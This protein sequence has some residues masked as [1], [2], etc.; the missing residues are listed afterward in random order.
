MSAK[1]ATGAGHMPM[2]R[3]TLHIP[4]PADCGGLARNTVL[5]P[6]S[7]GQTSFTAITPAVLVM[8]RSWGARSGNTGGG[9]RRVERFQTEEGQLAVDPDEQVQP[10]QRTALALP[11]MRPERGG[12]RVP[13]LALRVGKVAK[14]PRLL[15]QMPADFRLAFG[16]RVSRNNAAAAYG[17]IAASKHDCRWIFLCKG[18][19]F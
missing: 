4:T 19:M 15:R 5:S 11:G 7:A 12:G 16:S 2:M 3:N 8:T 10:R 1:P 14:A 17:A 18:D 6:G 9:R 13:G